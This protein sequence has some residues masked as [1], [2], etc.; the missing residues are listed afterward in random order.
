MID[1]GKVTDI[2][3]IVD[4]FCAEFEKFT[5]PFLIGNPP[6][7]KPQM[8]NSEIITIMILF[9]FGGFGNFKYFYLYYVQKYMKQE[10]PQ[11][12]FYN[13]FTELMQSNLMVLTM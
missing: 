7:K 13:R 3:C 4:T 6:K 12:V 8:S 9:Q 11:T 1:L 5:Q 2:F 10:F